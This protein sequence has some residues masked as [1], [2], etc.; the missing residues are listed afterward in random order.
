MMEDDEN[1]FE[2]VKYLKRLFD[3]FRGKKV[4]VRTYRGLKRQQQ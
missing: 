2:L 4:R 1:S 3:G